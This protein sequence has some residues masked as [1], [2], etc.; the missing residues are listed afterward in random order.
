MEM[1]ESVVSKAADKSKRVRAETFGGPDLIGLAL[2]EG[3]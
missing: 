1:E 2:T 3:R